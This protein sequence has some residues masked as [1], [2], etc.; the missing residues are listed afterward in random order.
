MRNGVKVCVIT[1]ATSGI[2]KAT[3]L[4]LA[5]TD[6]CLILVG[7][8]ERAGLELVRKIKAK[9]NSRQVIFLKTDLSSQRQVRS[10][11]G[12]IQ[13]RFGCVD[14][15]I[16]NAGAR[17]DQYGE[18][19]DRIERTFATNHLGHFLLTCL[20]LGPLKCA[21]SARV[22]TISSGTHWSAT[23]DSDWNLEQTRYNRMLAYSKSKLANVMF[24]YE[25]SRRVRHISIVSNSMDP[26][27]VAS[28]FCRNN[29]F[30]SWLRHVGYY[31]SRRGLVSPAK[32]AE[33][34]VHLAISDELKAVTGKYFFQK[35]AVRSSPASYDESA[36]RNLW[37][38]SVELTSLNETIGET[39][40]LVRP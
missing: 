4:A 31:A 36:I 12:S 25:L 13:Q 29:G 11:A 5:E 3:A 6:L 30:L 9:R 18:S 34:V 26:G 17:Y 16:N 40:A 27:G 2:G 22:I 7:R 21:P 14:I 39:W 20:L 19:E 8:R 35:Q 38:F 15:L 37:K 10:L 1:G 28:S 32:A 24:S 23:P 33:S